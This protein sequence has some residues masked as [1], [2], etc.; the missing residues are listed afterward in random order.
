MTTFVLLSQEPSYSR[1]F[2]KTFLVFVSLLF[3]VGSGVSF[4][5]EKELDAQHV[6]LKFE[7]PSSLACVACKVDVLVNGVKVGSIDNGKTE[8]FRLPRNSENKYE[9]VARLMRIIGPNSDTKTEA[10]EA[11]P[12][13]I[14]YA[15]WEINPWTFNL[16]SD[17]KLEI[18]IEKYASQSPWFLPK[19]LQ[20]TGSQIVSK[21]DDKKSEFPWDAI[22]S[23]AGVIGTVAGIAALFKK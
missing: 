17:R 9:I 11:D 19:P 8:R 6:V 10:I 15:R 23:I 21:L 5:V 22:G 3:A 7:R 13:S 2:M 16:D 14:V 1:D 12:G 4:Y 18:G 20:E